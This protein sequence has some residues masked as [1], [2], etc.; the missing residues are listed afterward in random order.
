LPLFLLS[1]AVAPT[2]HLVAASTDP[3]TPPETFQLRLPA[4]VYFLGVSLAS[5]PGT[6]YTLE[7]NGTP[8]P[9]SATP[10][11]PHLNNLI[12]ENVTPAGADTLFSSDLPSNTLF[13]V[14]NPLTEFSNPTPATD[15]GQS[16]TG[17]APGTPYRLRTLAVTQALGIGTLPD[18]FFT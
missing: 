8:A 17:L 10:P 16:L 15:H 3:G 4:G 9:D 14:T 11:K 1:G 18:V 6:A 5:G 2:P 12:V 13:Y 7:V